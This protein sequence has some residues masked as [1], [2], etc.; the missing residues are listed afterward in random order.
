MITATL[1]KQ[2]FLKTVRKQGFYKNM[3]VNIIMVL[4]A[5]YMLVSF[6]LLGLTLGTLLSEIP[7]KM[8]P[9]QILNAGLLYMML[10]GILMRYFVQPLNTVDLHVYQMLPIPRKSLV[11]YLIYR[12]LINPINYFWLIFLIPFAIKTVTPLYGSIAAFG[13]IITG[14]TISMFD[15]Q[16]AT[17][18]KRL[19]AGSLLKII[20][21]VVFIAAIVALEVFDIFS[22]AKLSSAYFTYAIQHPWLWIVQLALVLVPIGLQHNYFKNN[23]YIDTYMK[24]DVSTH[25]EMR[26]SFLDR[27]GKVGAIIT[28]ELKLIMRH[29]R[30]KSLIW[31]CFLYV[32]FGFLFFVDIQTDMMKLT[33]AILIVGLLML[34]YG[35]WVFSWNSSHFDAILTKNTTARD[36]VLANYFLMLAFCLIPF[37]LSLFYLFIFNGVFKYLFVSLLYC[38]GF[39]IPMMIYFATFNSKRVDLNNKSAMNYQGTTMKNFLVVIPVMLLPMVLYPILN[40]FGLS[41]SFFNIVGGLGIV[42][43]L[44]APLFINVCVKQ[45]NRRK[46][47]MADGFREIE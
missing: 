13:F 22:I 41:A 4:F 26:L 20:G 15:L 46:Y 42:G 37:V 19:F 17:Y 40:I 21:F 3:W 39:V 45:F 27:F 33:G 6:F 18:I 11:N 10:L 16:L 7:V 28:L 2:S 43:I 8:D 9:V 5:L 30:T 24:K 32:F 25:R 12:P 34:S 14:L 1:F 31:M 29:K 38:A 36:F 44:F 23:Y 47:K 35:Q